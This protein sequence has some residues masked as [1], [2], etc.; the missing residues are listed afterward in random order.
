MPSFRYLFTVQKK[1]ATPAPD[2]LNLPAAFAAPAGSEVVPTPAAK[3]LVA[4][5]LSLRAN[6][7][8]YDAPFTPPA[9]P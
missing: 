6:A 2:A 7:P 9:Q 1:G 5:L 8:L 4:Y 3:E